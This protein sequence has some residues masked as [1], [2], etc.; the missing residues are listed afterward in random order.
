M[1]NEGMHL[2]IDSSAEVDRLFSLPLHR[3]DYSARMV[4]EFTT[5]TFWCF[6]AKTKERSESV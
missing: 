5:L 6:C 3:I 4:V 1:K 2:R